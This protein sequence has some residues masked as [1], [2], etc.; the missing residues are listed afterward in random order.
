MQSC[1]CSLCNSSLTAARLFSLCNTL[2]VPDPYRAPCWVSLSLHTIPVAT[3]Q[4]FSQNIKSIEKLGR[5]QSVHHLV[6]AHPSP[7][8]FW[9][10]CHIPPRRNWCESPALRTSLPWQWPI[11]SATSPT[12]YKQ[13]LLLPAQRLS[14]YIAKH[15]PFS[16]LT[17]FFEDGSRSCSSGF[18]TVGSPWPWSCP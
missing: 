6:E 10:N 3:T 15:C 12:A 9:N 5:T 14:L 13:R 11:S 7:L 2:R 18:W 1:S 16:H 4:S 8:R 17:T